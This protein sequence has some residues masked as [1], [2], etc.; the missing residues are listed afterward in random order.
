MSDLRHEHERDLRSGTEDERA[1]EARKADERV[2]EARKADDRA[3]ETPKAG[4]RTADGGTTP[5]ARDTR[6]T[7]STRG[8]PNAPDTKSGADTPGTADRTDGP[9]KPGILPDRPERAPATAPE[10]GRPDPGRTPEPAPAGPARPMGKPSVPAPRTPAE[11]A[12]GTDSAEKAA[13]RAPH[14]T[15][16][17]EELDRLGHRM[18]RAIG[19]F[20]DD[21]RRAVREADAVLEEAASRLTRLL[22][23][24]R[25]DLHGSWHG[26]D[27]D[28]HTDTEEL[29][30]ALTKYRD[31]TRQLLTV[32]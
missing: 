29:R 17:A 23:E 16:G 26:G 3:S 6:E 12:A 19:G 1:D 13:G 9:T 27:G 8:V 18:E 28:E 7:R 10:A 4:G 15:G 5:G 30:V 31:M 24:R 21:P 14:G 32:L 22:E 11:P 20:V 2:N 25:S